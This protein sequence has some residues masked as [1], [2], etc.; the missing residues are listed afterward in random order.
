MTSKLAC[1]SRAM[2]RSRWVT[3]ACRLTILLFIGCYAF[4]IGRDDCPNS[5]LLGYAGNAIR[6]CL[7]WSQCQAKGFKRDSESSDA[8][9][10]KAIDNG[11]CRCE[12]AHGPLVDSDAHDA[13]P[14]CLF[15][16][17]QESDG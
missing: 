4:E 6:G 7:A 12:D 2:L 3:E 10:A 9:I 16:K 11:F 8:A 1:F 17:A 13:E 15:P 5:Q 14:E